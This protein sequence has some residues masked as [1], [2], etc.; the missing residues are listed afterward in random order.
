[1][2]CGGGGKG[3]GGGGCSGNGIKY[4]L[5]LV[6]IFDNFASKDADKTHLSKSE[7]KELLQQEFPGF[8]SV[9]DFFLQLNFHIYFAVADNNVLRVKLVML[10]ANY[11]WLKLKHV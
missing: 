7:L 3:G 11:L 10:E 1:M 6:Q 2:S 9:S 5:G 4:V 8:L